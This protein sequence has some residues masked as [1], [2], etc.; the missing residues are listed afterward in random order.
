[1]QSRYFDQVDFE[2]PCSEYPR[3]QMKRSSYFCLNGP[4]HFK[5]SNKEKETKTALVPF[6]IESMLGGAH[7]PLMPDETLIM[8]RDFKLPEGFNQGRVLLHLDAVDQRCEVYVNEH[9][10]GSSD[11]GYLP[12]IVD[13]TE[14]LQK[15]NHI[16][17]MI[18]DETDQ[19]WQC[20][21]KQKLAPK[22]IWYTPQSGIWQTV[23]LESV[24]H[25]YIEQLKITPL[26]DEQAV[27]V[28][29]IS[30]AVLPVTLEVFTDQAKGFSNAPIRLSL[31][32]SC[33]WTPDN[34]Y[35]YPL[36]ITME[37]DSV[38]SYFGL[39]HISVETDQKGHRR[40]FLNHQPLFHSGL[41]DQGYIS[42]G[43]MSWPCDQAMIDDILLAK[44]MGFNTLRKHI[45][46][47][48]LR[49]YYHCDRLGMLV[50]QDMIN[51]GE[52][53]SLL[54]IS[55]PLIT[56]KSFN[57]HHY[58]WFGRQNEA[59]RKVFFNQLEA[60]IDHLY[61]CVSIVM[62]VP[63]N[64]GWGQFDAKK[65]LALIQR[66]DATRL[67]DHASGWHDQKVGDFKSLHVYFKPYRFKPDKLNR[68]VIL[69]EFGGYNLAIEN[70][71]FSDVDFGYNRK[72]TIEEFMESIEKLYEEQ[73]IPAKK[74]GLCAA[75][76]TQLSDVETEL[77]G[78]ITYD[79]A[80][81]KVD[82]ERI[83]HINETLMKEEDDAE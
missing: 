37:E 38:E 3:P 5:R 77:N 27:E 29:V 67:I 64:E 55:S 15:I 28:T 7:A 9:W 45:K 75:I 76:Y 14:R 68:A 39:R 35:L 22:G 50:W 63:F 61:N 1:M 23:W 19:G 79:R 78:F 72:K 36:K 83:R 62:W 16:R 65:A 31:S 70:H 44:S 81:L 48:P 57:D 2:C 59:G 8:E 21:G 53:Y 34:P 69:T 60:M 12:L 17:V 56:G 20:R 18:W 47:E 51:G 46:I 24:P 52:S 42:D 10:V 43:M 58:R 4:W 74:Q 66:K 73:I 6:S 26:L 71:Q 54:T 82:P 33:A 80:V 25:N 40:L 30:K 13:I 32:T 49:W 41:L 11:F